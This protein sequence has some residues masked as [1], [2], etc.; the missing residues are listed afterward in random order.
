[1]S[2]FGLVGWNGPSEPLSDGRYFY[3][4]DDKRTRHAFFASTYAVMGHLA[5]S[6]GRVSED[7]ITMAEQIMDRMQL[8]LEQ[9]KHAVTLF[10]YGKSDTFSLDKVLGKLRKDI[11]RRA[12]IRQFIEIQLHVAYSDGDLHQ[13]EQDIIKSI[14]ISLEFNRLE[15]EHLER[16]V[17]SELLN[18]SRMS[19]NESFKLLGVDFNVEAEELKTVYRRLMGQHHPDRIQASSCSD[20]EMRLASDKAHRIKT[21]YEQ[22]RK[23]R[24]F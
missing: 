9:K 2:V 18:P 3:P 14:L 7:E 12:L 17:K 5:K 1:M 16:D 21:A 13:P 22:V 6:D 11:E 8:S 23:E 4:H 24:G 15:F 19:L 10:N 20:A